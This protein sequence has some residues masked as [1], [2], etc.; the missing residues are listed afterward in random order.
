MDETPFRKMLAELLLE[1]ATL[2]AS[3]KKNLQILAAR[4][5]KQHE[6]CQATATGIPEGL[7]Y[8]RVAIKYL[9]FD[10]E[11]TRRENSHLRKMLD[12]QTDGQ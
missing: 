2:P 11:A 5:N 8:L 9:L 4:I 7:D 3:D 10:L 1:I 12:L 6:Q